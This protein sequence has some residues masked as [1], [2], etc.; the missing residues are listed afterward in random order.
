[1]QSCFSDGAYRD[2]NKYVPVAHAICMAASANPR[3]SPAD[4]ILR[5]VAT[6]L[7]SFFVVFF[8]V[9]FSLPSSTPQ[10]RVPTYARADRRTY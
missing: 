5:R 7:P 1:V 2:A 3:I 6:C 9:F 10:K 8:L 4:P